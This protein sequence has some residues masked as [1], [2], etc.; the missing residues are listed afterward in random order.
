[1][2]RGLIARSKIELPDGALDARIGRVRAA[3]IE[4][5]LDALIIY[6]NNTQTAGVS[7]LTGFIPYWSEALLVV[8]REGEPR[9]V[10]ALTYRVKSWIERTSRIAEVIH[11]PRIGLE[12]ARIIAASKADAAVGIV[13]LDALSAGIADD[14][15]EGGPRLILSDANRLFA[16]LR[17]KADPAEVA[18]TFKAAAI[19]QRALAEAPKQQGALGTM[20]AAVEAEARRLGAEEIYIAAAPDLARDR[21]LVR[22][23]GEAV[24]GESYALR[25]TVAYKGSWVRFGR[26]FFRNITPTNLCTQVAEQFANAVAQLPNE[27]A[28]KPFS[29][30]LVEGCRLTQ[31]LGPLMGS[32]ITEAHR[33]AAGALVSVQVRANLEGQ[34][35]F[36]SAPVLT[37]N[38]GETAS[39]LADPAFD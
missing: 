2:R 38:Q 11:T 13:N 28:F 7:W 3:L 16:R 22:I 35:I 6:T 20:I 8:P 37:G 25:A 36:L 33:P 1:M 26:T 29:F 24:L 15:S 30:W 32:R 9:L 39:L 14:F 34:L 5:H 4:E 23:E 10:V 31:P 19:A 17:A 27:Q 18:L 12:A 21:R